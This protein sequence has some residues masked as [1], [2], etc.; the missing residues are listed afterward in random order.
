MTS[1]A[2]RPRRP[3]RVG[4]A[5]PQRRSRWECDPRTRAGR[6]GTSVKASPSPAGGRMRAGTRA[7]RV[8]TW[9]PGLRGTRKEAGNRR[10]DSRFDRKQGKLMRNKAVRLEAG[11]ERD[12]DKDRDRVM[13]DTGRIAVG[14][15]D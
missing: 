11:R 15:A 7:K 4:E 9:K 2:R 1:G 10:G 8:R 3:G 14:R 5:K 12:E 13:T 6:R